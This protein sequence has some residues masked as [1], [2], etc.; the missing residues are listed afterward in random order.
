MY[1]LNRIKSEF[2]AA[3]KSQG[4][5]VE[6]PV[7]INGR[8]TRTL[9]RVFEEGRNGSMKPIKV[10]FSRQLIETATDESIRG[11]IL[12]E[13]AH[14]IVS[15]TTREDH[16]HDWMFKEM[17]RK[18]GTDNDAPST[19]VHRTVEVQDKY[20][21]FCPNCGKIGGFSRKCK[22]IDRL[23]AGGCSCNTCGATNLYTVQNW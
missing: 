7:S 11:V 13:A 23:N 2:Y 22:T 10:E 3:C 4:M 19:K 15:Y 6:I 21:V 20:D 9:G 5:D 17:C 12:H 16:G 8:L 1:D 14:A 18:L